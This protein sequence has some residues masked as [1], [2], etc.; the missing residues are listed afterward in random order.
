MGRGPGWSS[1]DLCKMQ[2]YV[3]D[4]VPPK[5][6]CRLNPEWK[7]PT[8]RKAYW[9]IKAGKPMNQ[10]KGRPRTATT[11][12]AVDAVK[13]A[14][15]A[16]PKASL[17]VLARGAGLTRSSTYRLLREEL[18]LKSYRQCKVRKLQ[19]SQKD[20]RVTWCHRFLLRQMNRFHCKMRPLKLAHV[21]WSDEKI[22]RCLSTSTST[23]NRRFWS[24]EATKKAAVRANPVAGSLG[25]PKNRFSPGVMVSLLVSQ[26]AGAA[27][28]HFVP[29]ST[30][31][32]SQGY[33]DLIEYYVIP[34]ILAT[35][36]TLQDSEFQQDNAP[37]HASAHTRAYLKQAGLRILDFPPCSPDLSPLDYYAWGAIEEILWKMQPAG[38]PDVP[39]LQGAILQACRALP[40]E[41]V[42]AAIGQMQRRATLCIEARGGAFEHLM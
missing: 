41:E 20:A 24:A 6:I 15:N 10:Y 9:K 2:C 17:S 33:C 4:N 35:G 22:F 21:F 12:E 1:D 25:M 8:V 18:E 13:E 39:S 32:N 5:E 36:L 26:Y 30:K 28:P 34:Q 38:F 40:H 29:L 37:S 11:A 7:Y 42:T 3:A 31:L 27:Q 16:D 19:Q 14:V 23:Q